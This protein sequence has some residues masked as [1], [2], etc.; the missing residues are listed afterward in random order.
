MAIDKIYIAIA[1]QPDSGHA[2]LAYHIEAMLHQLGIYS[3]IQALSFSAS[4][5]GLAEP[6]P[7]PA[8]T[9]NLPKEV[10]IQ[11]IQMPKEEPVGNGPTWANPS[12][13]ETIPAMPRAKRKS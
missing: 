2:N 5:P 11:I 12:F 3:E 8:K 13:S 9:D 10:V 6:T 1:G 7:K 4:Q